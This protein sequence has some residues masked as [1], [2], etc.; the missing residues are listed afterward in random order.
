QE[1]MTT[2]GGAP[3]PA[4]PPGPPG[5]PGYPGPPGPMGPPG[6]PGEGIGFNIEEIDAGLKE[7]LT[8]TESIVA[9]D[10]TQVVD[11]TIDGIGAI[12]TKISLAAYIK[13]LSGP[14]ISHVILS[15]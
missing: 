7:R 3:G 14:I 15:S 6:E 4:G 9:T 1:Y 12:N 2:G 11:Y 8:Y 13:S 5:P 10:L